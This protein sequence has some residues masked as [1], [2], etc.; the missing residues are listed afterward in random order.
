VQYSAIEETQTLIQV[1][2][3]VTLMCWVV[4]DV[5]KDL[6]FFIFK[7]EGVVELLT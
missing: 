7:G 1:C 4:P 3:G 2:W 6:D 5:S